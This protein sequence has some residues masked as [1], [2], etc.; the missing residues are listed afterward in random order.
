MRYN[1]SNVEPG[2]YIIFNGDPDIKPNRVTNVNEYGF[3]VNDF[4]MTHDFN[5]IGDLLLESEVY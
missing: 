1:Q 5:D 2:D 3:Q 4:P